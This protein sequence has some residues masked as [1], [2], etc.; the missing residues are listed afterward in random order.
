MGLVQEDIILYLYLANE[1][2]WASTGR[3]RPGPDRISQ[4]EA[5]PTRG[6]E[7]QPKHGPN[8]SYK[9]HPVNIHI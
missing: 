5:R 6:P 3:T 9:Q 8:P 4:A 2:G 7:Q 1:P